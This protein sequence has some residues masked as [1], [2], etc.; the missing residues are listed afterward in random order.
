[1]SG[2]YKIS[3][4]LSSFDSLLIVAMLL[5]GRGGRGDLVGKYPDYK[6]KTGRRKIAA[7]F[8]AMQ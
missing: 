1:M 6:D 3:Q 7:F 2:L 5:G 8:T 4:F